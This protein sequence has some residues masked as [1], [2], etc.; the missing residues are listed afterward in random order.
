MKPVVAV[1]A[2]TAIVCSL[3]ALVAGQD[4]IPR[5]PTPHSNHLAAPGTDRRAGR[6]RVDDHVLSD[7]RGP[8]LGLGASYFTSLWR[9]KHDHRALNPTSPSS[10][11]RASTTTACSQWSATTPVGMAARSPPFRS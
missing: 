9:S 3:V 11:V 8:F 6:V 4:A 5:E 7:E 1:P 10:R 2:V